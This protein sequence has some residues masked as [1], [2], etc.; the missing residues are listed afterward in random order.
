[1]AAVGLSA[2]LAETCIRRASPAYR[3]SL[4]QPSDEAINIFRLQQLVVL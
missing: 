4:D 1:M 3:A 2:S